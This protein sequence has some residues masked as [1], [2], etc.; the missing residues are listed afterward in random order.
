MPAAGPAHAPLQATAALKH[1]HAEEAAALRDHVHQAEQAERQLLT[2]TAVLEAEAQKLRA[3]IAR[4]EGRCA[5]GRRALL[6]RG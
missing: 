5:Y 2:A 6:C 4:L 1:A 3:E